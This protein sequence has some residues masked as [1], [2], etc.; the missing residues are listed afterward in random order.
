MTVG[1]EFHA[2]GNQLDGAIKVLQETEGVLCSTNMGATAIGTGI[3]ATPGYAE[4][5]AAHAGP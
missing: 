2:F 5:C 1:Q 4:K 3:T